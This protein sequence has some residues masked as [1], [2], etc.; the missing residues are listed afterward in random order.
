M[1]A[2]YRNIRVL[3]FIVASSFCALP[4]LA[5][6]NSDAKAPDA[7]S[8][9][10]PNS[11]AVL[12]FSED[13]NAALRD[14]EAA[15]LAIFTSD[16]KVALDL[17]KNA[18]AEIGKA[19]KAGASMSAG[20]TA[21]AA[22]AQSAPG[23]IAMIPVDGQLVVADDFVPTK[24]KQAHIANANKNI[25]NGDHK[26]AL[27]ELHLGE[28]E[29]I[30]NR[31]WMPVARAEKHLDQAVAL[32]GEQ[33]YYEANLALKAIGGSLTIESVALTEVPKKAQTAKKAE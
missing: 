32:I 21:G 7:K 20:S 28:V 11:A 29:I 6:T 30:Y 5:Q 19:E 13:G 9:A 2:G 14:I 4:A 31:L 25:G 3:A 16:P 12:K 22:G 1:K 24:E 27:K 18:Q 26:Q 8:N 15:R 23:K 33:K 17:I 10:H